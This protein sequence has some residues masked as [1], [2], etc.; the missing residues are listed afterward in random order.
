MNFI[1][2]NRKFKSMLE[3]N[4]DQRNRLEY[5]MN[6]PNATEIERDNAAFELEVVNQKIIVL[7][8]LQELGLM[9][10]ET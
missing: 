3:D 1:E 2:V 6:W 5:I 4:L 10:K 9:E 8:T 7:E